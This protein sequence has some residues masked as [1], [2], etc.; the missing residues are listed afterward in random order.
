M[1]CFQ[2]SSS[3][4]LQDNPFHRVV[5]YINIKIL[6]PSFMGKI[7]SPYQL[8]GLGLLYVG[9]KMK[10]QLHRFEMCESHLHCLRAGII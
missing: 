7:F 9:V 8:L 10:A 6:L 4:L 2:F 5:Q 1:Y 3:V